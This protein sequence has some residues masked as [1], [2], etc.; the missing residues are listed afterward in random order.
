MKSDNANAL[1]KLE[2]KLKSYRDG[3]IDPV[4][5]IYWD[6][7][8]QLNLKAAIEN[9]KAGDLVLD[10]GCGTGAIMIDLARVKRNCF[11]I[12]PLHEIS[13]S[14][15]RDNAAKNDV[16]VA[17]IQSFS[18]HL[19][20]QSK[21][22]DMVLLFSTLQHVAN[23]DETLREVK[24]VLKDNGMLLISVPMSKNLFTMLRS[25]KKPEHFTKSFGLD[26]LIAV[27]GRNGFNIIKATGCGFFPP[28]GHKA[29]TGFHSLLG[30]GLT[31]KMLMLLDIIAKNAP[32]TASSVVLVCEVRK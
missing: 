31:R 1:K 23:Q 20:F 2:T 17:L 3:Q 5:R 15:A 28:L 26:E 24:R 16:D 11:G 30:A 10:V 13:L 21:I 12:D 6:L 27:L 8:Y 25:P 9:T 29:L 22:F 32:S 18:E 4:T 7:H 14:R 19:P